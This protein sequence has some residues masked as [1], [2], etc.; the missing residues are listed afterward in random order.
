MFLYSTPQEFSGKIRPLTALAYLV[1]FIA[2]RG[3]AFL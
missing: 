1:I 2:L 3:A